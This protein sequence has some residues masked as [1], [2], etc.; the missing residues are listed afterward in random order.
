MRT[1]A[2][3]IGGLGLASLVLCGGLALAYRTTL[4]RIGTFLEAAYEEPAWVELPD[5]DSWWAYLGHHTATFSLVAMTVDEGGTP[6]PGTLIAHHGDTARPLASVQKLVV[7]SAFERAVDAGD[8]S[9]SSPVPLQRWDS[10]YLPGLD[11][12]AH[13]RAYDALDV[14]HVGGKATA[15][16]QTVPLQALVDAMITQ[17]DNAATDVLIELL[18]DELVAETTR[19]GH[20]P[21]FPLFA[22]TARVPL[23]CDAPLPDVDTPAKRAAIASDLEMPSFQVQRDVLACGTPSAPASLYATLLAG[24]VSGTHIS[25]SASERMRDA[26][27]WPMDNVGNQTRFETFGTKGGAFPGVLNEASFLVPATGDFAGQ[28]RVVVLFTNEMSG[29]AWLAGVQSFAHQ[30]FVVRLASDATFA[31]QVQTAIGEK[32]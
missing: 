26:L 5:G 28:K 17:S 16:E 31:R 32:R 8:L 29:S 20:A 27:D 7:L 23:G 2:R 9:P 12:G 25:P 3:W 24:V 22:A 13:I 30:D 10:W 15:P 1:A 19:L 14:P 4:Q 21:L 6:V 11:G 18:G